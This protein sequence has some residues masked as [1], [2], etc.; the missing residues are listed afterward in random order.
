MRRALVTRRPLVLIPAI[1]FFWALFY[2]ERGDSIVWHVGK[3]F[4]ASAVASIMVWLVALVAEA[5][6][7]WLSK[8]AP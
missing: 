8:R 3:A 2:V 6:Y 5:L 7:T 1:V 4:L